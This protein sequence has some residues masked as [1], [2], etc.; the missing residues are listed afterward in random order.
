MLDYFVIRVS[1]DLHNIPSITL[2]IR[3]EQ[4]EAL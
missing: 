4:S 3:F 2:Y 1:Y